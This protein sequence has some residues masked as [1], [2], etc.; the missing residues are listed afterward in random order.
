V[1]AFEHFKLT[2]YR[3]VCMRLSHL[4]MIVTNLICVLIPVNDQR[5]AQALA[6]GM[7]LKSKLK[8]LRGVAA[9]R[10][11]NDEWFD[12]LDKLIGEIESTHAPKRNRYAHDVW[13]LDVA[14]DEIVRFYFNVSMPKQAKHGQER[15]P[16]TMQTPKTTLREMHDIADAIDAT[17]VEIDKIRQEYVAAQQRP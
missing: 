16:T 9:V 13:A 5:V 4:E 11:P 14:E 15:E 7:E 6:G 1:P 8:T 2:H 12:R 10:R 3:T 17:A